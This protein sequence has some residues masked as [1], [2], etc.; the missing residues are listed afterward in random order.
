MAYYIKDTGTETFPYDTE[1]KAALSLN[2]LVKQLQGYELTSINTIV[3]NTNYDVTFNSAKIPPFPIL[4]QAVAISC[5]ITQKNLTTYEFSSGFYL[6]TPGTVFG[7]TSFH[8]GNYSFV[9]TSSAELLP[10]NPI[11]PYICQIIKGASKIAPFPKFTSGV[12]RLYNFLIKATTI[13]FY[14]SRFLC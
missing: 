5:T 4:D 2:R 13:E 14:S 6:A 1:E 10:G 11:I 9:I 7:F 12:S 3:T 8:L